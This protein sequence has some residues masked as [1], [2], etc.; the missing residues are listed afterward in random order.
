MP[1]RATLRIANESNAA[2]SITTSKLDIAAE[3]FAVEVSTTGSTLSGTIQIQGSVSGENWQSLPLV[4]TT[5]VV[6]T[7]VTVSGTQTDLITVD[8]FPFESMRLVYT[9]TSGTGTLSAWVLE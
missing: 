9:A 5:G 2:A 4:S 3:R 8:P 7:A 1:L 6:S